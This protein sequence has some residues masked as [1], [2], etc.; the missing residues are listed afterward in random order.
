MYSDEDI[1]SEC[2]DLLSQFESRRVLVVG[3]IMLD[4][5]WIGEATRISPEAPVPIL[6][7]RRFLSHPGGAGNV[8][9]NLSALGANVAVVAAIGD[10]NSGYE[11]RQS[12]IRERLCADHLFVD[13]GRI[14]TVKTRIIADKQQI[15]RLDEED[16]HSLSAEQ[17][18]MML[19]KIEALVGS[20]NCAIISDYAKGVV[21]AALATGV[22]EMARKLAVPVVVDPKTSDA[23]KYRGA[24]LMKP[25]RA[26]LSLLTGL[27]VQCH[28]EA[29]EACER[30]SAV[31]PDAA[32]LVTEGSEGM[33]LRLPR[34]GYVHLPTKALDVFDVTGAGDTVTAVTALAV[35][36]NA[37][38]RAAAQLA[39]CA[40]GIVVGEFGCGT[41]STQRLR[42]SMR[43]SR[44]S[45][46]EAE[47]V[48]VDPTVKHGRARAQARSF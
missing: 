9:L 48:E 25:N 46:A 7:K 18:S 12:L 28:A 47:Q 1:L 42:A 30:L 33:T 10:D 37:D 5:Y 38:F 20:C 43:D 27:S 6:E 34:S 16:R 21:T 8:A 36:C 31:I 11:L 32:I 19:Q 22:I 3:D 35:A 17:E 15:V 24:T 44:S 45:H 41:V 39:N 14:T 23:R 13:P 40:A 26:E 2:E 4:R 29:L